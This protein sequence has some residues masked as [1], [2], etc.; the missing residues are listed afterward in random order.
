MEA[1]LEKFKEETSRLKILNEERHKDRENLASSL[2]RYSLE[3]ELK[4]EEMKVE[5]DLLA[6]SKK[7]TS[8]AKLTGGFY[9]NDEGIRF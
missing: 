6:A 3:K 1:E 5:R 2:K 4:M 8:V 7:K 9:A